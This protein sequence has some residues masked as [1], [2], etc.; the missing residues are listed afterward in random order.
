MR[1]NVEPL[2]NGMVLI[3]AIHHQRIEHF[4]QALKDEDKRVSK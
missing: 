2:G 1:W 3:N 4:I